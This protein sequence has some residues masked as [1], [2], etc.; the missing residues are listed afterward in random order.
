[1]GQLYASLKTGHVTASVALERLVAFSAKNRFYRA[2]R[3]LGGPH[4][5]DRFHF[6]LSVGTGAARGSGAGILKVEQLHALARDVFYSRRGRNQRPRAPELMNTCSCVTLTLACIVYWQ[7]GALSGF[8]QCDPAGNGID[9]PLLEHVRP[10]EC[11]NVVLLW[12]IHPGSAARPP[13]A[14][15]HESECLAYN[16]IRFCLSP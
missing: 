3:E 14:K 1:M 13:S 11:D 16:I 9:L 12:P 2:N 8:N 10:I 7:A 15:G 6:A 4:L 5:Q